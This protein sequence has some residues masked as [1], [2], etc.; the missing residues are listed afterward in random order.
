M[1]HIPLKKG[2]GLGGE[3]EAMRVKEGREGERNERG[4]R[5]SE[6]GSKKSHQKTLSNFITGPQSLLTLNRQKP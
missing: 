5:E 3:E 1:A 4:K 6:K 2:Q